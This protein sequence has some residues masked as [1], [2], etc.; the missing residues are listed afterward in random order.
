MDPKPTVGISD[1]SA[2]SN[3]PIWYNDI[4]GDTLSW[5]LFNPFE[6]GDIFNKIANTFIKR[7]TSD[8]IYAIFSHGTKWSLLPSI[9]PRLG[10]PKSVVD[11]LAKTSKQFAKDMKEGKQIT[12][13][14]YSCES[15]EGDHSLA[16]QISKKYENITV[17]GADGSIYYEHPKLPVVGK[18][19]GYKTFKKGEVIATKVHAIHPVTDKITEGHTTIVEKSGENAGSY[20]DSPPSF[21]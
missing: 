9:A 1:Y 7:Q 21:K 5:N 12:L 13:L 14:L 16:E 11:Y 18:D 10:S 4:K 19:V 17:V 2:F 15:A 20:D 6:V 8:G 3:N